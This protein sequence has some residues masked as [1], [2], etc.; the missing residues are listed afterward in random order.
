MKDHV[1][2]E[3][4]RIVDMVTAVMLAVAVGL[5]GWNLQQTVALSR[6][7]AKIQ[8]DRFRVQDGLEVWKEIATI[9]ELIAGLPTEVPPDWFVDRVASLEERLKKMEDS[10][11]TNH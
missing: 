5:G 3:M 11:R 7:V 8:A 2:E 6:E 9:R 10:H 4:R 1:G